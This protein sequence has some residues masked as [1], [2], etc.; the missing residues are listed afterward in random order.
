MSKKLFIPG[1]SDVS[2]GVFEAM[3]APMIGHRGREY[4]QLFMACIQNLKKLMF[5]ENTI[6]IVPSSSTGLMEAAVRNCVKKKCLN[7]GNGAFSDR[8]H[9]ITKDNGKKAD[10]LSFEWGEAPL[11]ETIDE[12]LSSGEYDALTIVH[13]ETST[14]VTAP[15]EDIAKVAGDYDVSFLVDAVS[16]MGGIKVDV[17]K[18]G[19]DVCL[20]GVQKAM[21]LPAG[22]A[23]CSVSDAAL[24]KAKS[25]ENRG[26]YF[27]FLVYLKYLNKKQTPT[28][29]AISIMQ[30]LRYQL[31]QII[32]HEGMDN[33]FLRHRK[34]GEYCRAWARKNLG[35][36]PKE[37][38]ASDTVSCVTKTAGIDIAD[39]DL[40]LEQRGYVFAKGYGRLADQTFRV[41]HMGER[42]LDELKQYLYV[43]DEILGF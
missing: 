42:T 30:G 8:W 37:R 7:V 19:I 9:Q 16:S 12:R 10:L 21:A 6:F 25:I 2:Q 5:T 28:T 34:M 22:L 1:P 15:L 13:N 36:L 24:K 33:R 11:P 40:K 18:L 23:I 31:D 17:D 14:G 41:A 29:G 4:T 35:I 38:F 39:L 20:F 32:N 3:S 43:I 26:Y 27:D